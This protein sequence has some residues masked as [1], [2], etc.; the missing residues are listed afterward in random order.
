MREEVERVVKEEGWNKL[1]LQKMHKIDSF[2]KESQ[3]FDGLGSGET[4]LFHRLF[5]GLVLTLN[6]SF[7]D[8]YDSQGL[9][10][11]GWYLRP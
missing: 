1:A 9:Y 10:F 8:A 6:P 3:R 4:S 7:H 2:L 5:F 11:L